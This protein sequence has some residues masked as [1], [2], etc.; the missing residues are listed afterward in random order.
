MFVHL[1]VILRAIPLGL[2]TDHL[3][4]ISFPLGNRQANKEDQSKERQWYKALHFGLVTDLCLIFLWS[5]D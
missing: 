2:H 3:T 1:W 4:V 5:R